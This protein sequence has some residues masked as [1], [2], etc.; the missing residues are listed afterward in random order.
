MSFNHQLGSICFAGKSAHAELIRAA[1]SGV[2]VV[3]IFRNA[4]LDQSD[5][6]AMDCHRRRQVFGVGCHSAAGTF[7]VIELAAIGPA[8][9]HQTVTP[10]KLMW[11]QSTALNPTVD[12]SWF[13]LSPSIPDRSETDEKVPMTSWSPS[14][15]EH[16]AAICAQQWSSRQR[17]CSSL[18]AHSSP[19]LPWFPL[20]SLGYRAEMSKPPPKLTVR[21]S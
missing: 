1:S 13:F 12:S 15:R 10:I 6:V 11:W 5:V 9:A 8:A 14:W 18:A 21:E 3:P 7:G 2:Y 19:S 16:R 17:A 20:A 4:T